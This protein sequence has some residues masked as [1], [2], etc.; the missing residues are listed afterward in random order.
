MT[1]ANPWVILGLVI[2]LGATATLSYVR[3]RSDANDKCAVTVAKI[4][5]DAQAETDK[6]AAKKQAE[7][8]F[9]ASQQAIADGLYRRI[10]GD[11]NKITSKPFYDGDCLDDDGLSVVNAAFAGT[12]RGAGEPSSAVPGD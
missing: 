5:A 1:L 9:L 4:Y 2:A 11:V 10:R 12:R 6:D 3:G 8:E 7:A